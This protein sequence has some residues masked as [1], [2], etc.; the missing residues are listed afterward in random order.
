MDKRSSHHFS[1][2]GKLP[3]RNHPSNLVI[4]ETIADDDEDESFSDDEDWEDIPL[5]GAINVTIENPQALVENGETR[6]KSKKHHQYRKLKYGLHIATIPLFL[7]VL[8]QRTLWARDKR[9][10]RRLRRAVPAI[11]AKKFTKWSHLPEKERSDSLRTL[12]LGLVHWF[13]SNYQINSNGFRQNFNRLQYLLKFSD[14]KSKFYENVLRSQHW[15]Y[16]NRPSDVA[17]IEVIRQMARK[18]K[19]NRD[20]LVIFFLITLKNMLPEE[21]NLSLCF[22][23]PLHDYEITCSNVKWQTENGVGR[24]PNRF[25]G[26]LLRPYFWIELQFPEDRGCELY[27]ID[28]V[29]HLKESEIVARYRD[30]EPIRHYQPSMDVKP[31][32]NQAF[33]YVINIDCENGFIKDVSPRY[34]KNTCY[35]YFKVEPTTVFTKSLN[36]KSYLSFQQ[37]LLEY[38]KSQVDSEHLELMKRI[39]MKNYAVPTTLTGIKRSD[40]FIIPSMLKGNETLSFASKPVAKFKHHQADQASYEESVYWKSD[41]IL[42]KCKQHWALLGRSIMKGSHPLKLKEHI[43]MRARREKRHD[44]YEIKELY[45]F[46]QTYPS[47]KIS[48]TH[49]DKSGQLYAITE[50]EDLRNRHGNVEIYSTDAKPDGFELVPVKDNVKELIKQF[51]KR[52]RQ[53]NK[54]HQIR[55]LDVVSGFDFKQKPGYA[56]PQI[57]HILVSKG[58]YICI[59]E[60]VRHSKEAAALQYWHELLS[61]LKI[62]KRLNETYGSLDGSKS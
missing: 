42:L 33:H 45:S 22:A 40:C 29:V 10:N 56:L 58:D 25:D 20:I 44:R 53:K 11:I 47:P 51:N 37:S 14:S 5:D 39:S 16:G 24:V 7:Q 27:V 28:P 62:Q 17:D 35:R 31:N 46:E 32:I 9:L 57:N 21:A 36:Y 54:V 48:T 8:R 4:E 6:R 49:R 1:Y 55:Y 61:K 2:D 18:K 34:L 12:L 50:V 3:N 60:L 30:D 13:R 59:Q 19:S 52:S 43:T 23:L 41:V 15:Y 26:D 38:N